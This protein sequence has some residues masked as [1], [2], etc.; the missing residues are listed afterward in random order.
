M[1]RVGLNEMQP[2]IG[3]DLRLECDGQPFTGEVVE[4]AAGLLLA[5]DFYVKGI[6]NGRSLQWWADGTLRAE[7]EM[8]NGRFTGPFRRCHNNGRRRPDR[9]R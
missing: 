8:R 4:T 3:D 2:E 6:R 7:G 9:C 5:Q 1:L